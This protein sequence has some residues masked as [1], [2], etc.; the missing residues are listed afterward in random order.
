MEK[1]KPKR[2][3]QVWKGSNVSFFPFF[4]FSSSFL[5]LAIWIYFSYFFPKCYYLI[6]NWI[7]WC[8]LN[9]TFFIFYFFC[10]I[11]NYEI[12]TLRKLCTF[13]A[14]DSLWH[15]S[16]TFFIRWLFVLFLSV[17]IRFSI[18][19]GSYLCYIPI[20]TNISR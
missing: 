1:K 4:L 5:S 2:L 3:Y 15:F 13:F 8:I 16:F 19:L 17:M 10:G 7:G 18:L 20:S 12:V 11:E 6:V 14:C 9:W